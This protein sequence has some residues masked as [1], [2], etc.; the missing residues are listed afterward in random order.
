[1][2]ITIKAKLA[3]TFAVVIAL[4]AVSMV[5]AMQNLG[6]LNSAFAGAMNGNV[7]RIQKNVLGGKVIGSELLN[8]DFVALAASFGVSA[9]RARTPD[10]LGGALREMLATDGPSLIEV[11]VGELPDFWKVLY[12]ESSETTMPKEE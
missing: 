9:T 7:K 1:M 8:P 10:E 4:S 6:S 3:A 12:P 11:P 2:R 5:V